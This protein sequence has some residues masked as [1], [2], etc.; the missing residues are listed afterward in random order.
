MANGK[1]G[2][3]VSFLMTLPNLSERRLRISQMDVLCFSPPP[4]E[5]LRA[6]NST[7]ICTLTY[8][9]LNRG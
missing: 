7:F 3:A 2:W 9:W 5:H 8:F 1:L 6:E 4:P